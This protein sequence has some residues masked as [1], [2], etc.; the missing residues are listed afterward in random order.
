MLK[1][2]PC[3]KIHQHG[4]SNISKEVYHYISQELFSSVVFPGDP[5][6][7]RQKIYSF[8]NGD[9]CSLTALSMCAHN[10]THIDAPYH[11]FPDGKTVEQIPL[12]V[13]VGPA[14]VAMHNGN[15]TAADAEKILASARACGASERIL[16][17]GDAI[18]TAESAKVFA[19]ARVR[20]LGN[21][22]QTFGPPRTEMIS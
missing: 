12:E 7:E 9:I 15:V 6:P 21:E 20:I 16:I 8:E 22:S 19:S 13:F 1:T 5:A 2:N 4:T 11:F 17:R 18:V 14:Y 3:D 10:G